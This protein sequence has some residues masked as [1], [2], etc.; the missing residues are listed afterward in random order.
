M[1]DEAEKP[2]KKGKKA[3]D[4]AGGAAPEKAERK[5]KSE[6]KVSLATPVTRVVVHDTPERL[7]ALGAALDD[8]RA[9]GRVVG[10]IECEPGAELDVKVELAPKEDT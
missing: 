3:A 10:E 2:K 9:A 5:E 7:A 6:Q 8:V 4:D 1:A